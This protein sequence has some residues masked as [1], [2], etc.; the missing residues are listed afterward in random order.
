MNA[1][2]S[3]SN[4]QATTSSNEM[5]AVLKIV[6]ADRFLEELVMPHIDVG[7]DSIDW[8]RIFKNHFCSGHRA[9]IS[10]AY[11]VWTDQIRPRANPIEA[12]YSMDDTLKVACLRALAIRWGVAER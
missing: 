4:S 5:R 10:F 11:S 3:I 12:A 2:L 9:A 7:N 6:Q 8:D 1:A